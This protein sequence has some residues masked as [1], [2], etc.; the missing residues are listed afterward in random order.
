MTHISLEQ[1]WP[2]LLRCF[3][4]ASPA[5]VF[6]ACLIFLPNSEV[7]GCLE[8]HSTDNKCC[9]IRAEKNTK[10]VIALVLIVHN[11]LLVNDCYIVHNS[12]LPILFIH[13]NMFQ[14]VPVRPFCLLSPAPAFATVLSIKRT[15]LK[16]D[17][18]YLYIKNV[19]VFFFFLRWLHVWLNLF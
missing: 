7:L 12:A 18:R 2:Q 14:S 8:S 1:L 16:N 3:L 9:L 15:I 13:I 4:L 5:P 19:F 6:S 11:N 10:N 17:C